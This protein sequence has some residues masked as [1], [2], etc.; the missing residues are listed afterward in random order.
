M[1]NKI[2]NFEFKVLL[3]ITHRPKDHNTKDVSFLTLGLCDF[4]ATSWQLLETEMSAGND[5]LTALEQSNHLWH[6]DKR[7]SVVAT[8]KFMGLRLPL[9]FLVGLALKDSR[10]EDRKLALVLAQQ[11]SRTEGVGEDG[12]YAFRQLSQGLNPEESLQ[13]VLAIVGALPAVA[14]L[15]EGHRGATKKAVERIYTSLLLK[16]NTMLV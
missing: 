11:W 8:W 9:P 13:L 1:T 4:S 16:A 3:S 14:E 6:Q 7:L 12:L 2:Q 15:R 10:P 5:W